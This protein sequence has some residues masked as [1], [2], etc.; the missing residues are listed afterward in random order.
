MKILSPICKLI[1]TCWQVWRGKYFNTSSKKMRTPRIA[2][3]KP[4][5]FNFV[6]EVHLSWNIDTVTLLT[7]HVFKEMWR[8]WQTVWQWQR[9]PGHYLVYTGVCGLTSAIFLLWALSKC[10]IRA[11]WLVRALC[12]FQHNNFTSFNRPIK[13]INMHLGVWSPFFERTKPRAGIHNIPCDKVR[14]L[15]GSSPP[16]AL[17]SFEGKFNTESLLKVRNWVWFTLMDSKK[18]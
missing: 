16:Y 14:H 17:A 9:S 1:S 4:N 15:P 8:A 3:C 2:D 13:L 12:N 11:L 10:H 18:N 6:W 5:W 7:H